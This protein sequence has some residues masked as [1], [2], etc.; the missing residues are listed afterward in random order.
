MLIN[1]PDPEV[2]KPLLQRKS[3]TPDQIYLSNGQRFGSSKR[4][5][6]EPLVV[7]ETELGRS[8]VLFLQARAVF[9]EL[10]CCYKVLAKALTDEDPDTFVPVMDE[11]ASKIRH[12]AEHHFDLAYAYLSWHTADDYPV[13]HHVLVAL[14]VYRVGA[15]S[16][17]FAPEVLDSLIKAALSMNISML[18]LQARLRS[19]TEPLSRDQRETIRKHPEQGA[20]KLGLL[21]VR[22]EMWLDTVRL[23]HELPD[24]SGYPAQIK[25]EHSGSVLLGVCDSFNARMAQREYRANFTAE[26]AV[27][28][29][30]AHGNALS[31]DFT[32][33]ILEELGIYP[34]GSLVQLAGGAIGCSLIRGETAITPTVLVFKNIPNGGTAPAL[35]DT[36]REQNAVKF[37]L[38]RRDLGRLPGLLELL[39]KAV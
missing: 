16:G 21:G 10:T 13:M 1:L 5:G 26:Q 12:L 33:I 20:N 30:F 14:T 31:S 28:D 8:T 15:N 38:P 4:L 18:G 17:R 36:A 22:D 29:L 23:H 34:A 7:L 39:G 24:G 6:N 32:A 19:Q 11:L 27:K 3:L 35:M 25:N 37:A 9:D 2:V